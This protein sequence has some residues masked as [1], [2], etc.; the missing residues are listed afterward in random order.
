MPKAKTTKRR[1]IKKDAASEPQEPIRETIKEGNQYIFKNCTGAITIKYL[2][3]NKAIE[4]PGDD[5]EH[6]TKN[7]LDDRWLY[8]WHINQQINKATKEFLKDPRWEYIERRNSLQETEKKLLEEGKILDPTEKDKLILLYYTGGAK[9]LRNY[10]NNY[11][12]HT[13]H[14]FEPEEEKEET[15]VEVVSTNFRRLRG[16]KVDY[17]GFFD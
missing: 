17:N 11:F 14:T 15:R 10:N 8:W 1:V 9:E 12:E 16:K 13:Y 3:K 5:N 7:P 2:N 4:L 6:W